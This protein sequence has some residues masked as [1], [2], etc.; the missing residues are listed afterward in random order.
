MFKKTIEYKN[1]DDELETVI[2]W[3]NLS[4]SELGENLNL[5][6]EFESLQAVLSIPHT[7]SVDETQTVFD[8]VKRLTRLSY[9]VRPDSK[10]FDK[11]D[12]IWDEFV[13]LGQYDAFIWGLFESTNKGGNDAND[14]MMAIFPED[15]T[16][17]A[18]AQAK[19]QGLL[20]EDVVAPKL[21][22]VPTDSMV[23]VEPKETVKPPGPKKPQDMSREELLE[24]YRSKNNERGLSGPDQ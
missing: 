21:S 3:F 10:H 20:L 1:W 8:F 16:E 9:G 15:L 13:S 19:E 18:I 14:F 2:L 24:A 6:T 4:K 11:S 22:G 23:D 7:L 5:L 17:Q 12:A